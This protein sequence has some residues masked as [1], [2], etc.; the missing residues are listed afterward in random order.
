[1]VT[2]SI[3]I[4]GILYIC[5]NSDLQEIFS[6]PTGPAKQLMLAIY[7]PFGQTKD[8]CWASKKTHVGQLKYLA[9]PQDPNEFFLLG[10][11]YIFSGPIFNIYIYYNSSGYD[12]VF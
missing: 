10:P 8:L 7:W 1:M 2:F 12:P 9:G 6:R 4:K 5:R 11:L 3:N